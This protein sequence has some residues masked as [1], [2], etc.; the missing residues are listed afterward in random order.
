MRKSGRQER[1]HF[2]EFLV[3]WVAM[4]QGSDARDTMKGN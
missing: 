4:H 2:G 1:T 3:S